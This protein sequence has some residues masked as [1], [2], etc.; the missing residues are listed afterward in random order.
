MYNTKEN[1]ERLFLKIANE[2]HI[3]M[4]L[5]EHI[6][7]EYDIVMEEEKSCSRTA[8]DL[9][10][11]NTGGKNDYLVLKYKKCHAP[12][13]VDR[14]DEIYFEDTTDRL[15]TRY[16]Q[17]L[18]SA[19]GNYIRKANEIVGEIPICPVMCML[20]R[21]NAE[22]GYVSLAKLAEGFAVKSSKA[23]ENVLL[24][25]IKEIERQCEDDDSVFSYTVKI[26]DGNVKVNKN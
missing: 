11:E 10:N 8:I 5:L 19:L 13:N 23:V 20:S 22:Y 15:Q 4:A 12:E 9:L 7:S 18:I 16:Y 17:S 24:C 14:I 2:H 6:V 1:L 26:E 25:S 21:L 3:N